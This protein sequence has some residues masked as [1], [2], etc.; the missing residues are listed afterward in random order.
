LKAATLAHEIS[1]ERGH[2]APWLVR[3]TIAL[4]T[5]SPAAS[6]LLAGVE[7]LLPPRKGTR[8]R[9]RTLRP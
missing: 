6:H 1:F 5:G 8:G 2:Q 3:H 4:E 9:H 7:T